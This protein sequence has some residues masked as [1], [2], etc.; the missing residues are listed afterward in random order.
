MGRLSPKKL[1]DGVTLKKSQSS[2]ISGILKG[3]GLR[4]ELEP[5]PRC[6]SESFPRGKDH[7][8]LLYTGQLTGWEQ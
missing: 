1:A 3:I 7:R 6:A 4:H 8:A 5:F 2:S